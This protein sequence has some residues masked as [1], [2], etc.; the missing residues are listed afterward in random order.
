M[1][2]HIKNNNFTT[3]CRLNKKNLIKSF[4]KVLGSGN[5]ILS[6]E[7][8]NFE[9]RFSRYFNM[10][11]CISLAN[12]TDAIEIALRACGIKKNNLVATAANAGMYTTTAALLIGAKPIFVDVDY[13]TNSINFKEACKAISKG[14]KAI[15]VTHL[16]GLAN[17][18]IEKIAQIC[19]KKKVFLIEDCA[20]AHGAKIGK[21]FVGSFG[22]AGTFSF[23]PTKNLGALGDG[24]AMITNKNS[25]AKMAL[26]LRQYGWSKKYEVSI[27]GGRNSRLD[28]IQASFLSKLLLNL[29]KLNE[30]RRSIANF[31]SKMIQNKDIITPNQQGSNFVAHQ[32]VIKTNRRNSLIKYLNKFNIDSAILYPI[33]DYKQATLKKNY[34]EIILNNTEKLSKEVLS[35]PCNPYLKSK[36]INKIVKVLNSW[37]A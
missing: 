13:N 21:N 22:D 11:F 8:R 30:K 24:G 15:I 35:I 12:G 3:F 14:A 7:V 28:E 18:D 5:Y 16:Y 31:Y 25:V 23:Y 2:Y 34:S 33:P 17:P 37:R 27:P 26:K 6:N 9:K 29:N 20:Q 32:Y 4:L 10:K 1:K 36:E 19:R